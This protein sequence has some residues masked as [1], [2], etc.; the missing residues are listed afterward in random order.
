[1]KQLIFFVCLIGTLLG[2][3]KLI[4][5]QELYDLVDKADTIT[6]IDTSRYQKVLF[7]SHDKEDIKS[8]KEA[9]TLVK[10]EPDDYFALACISHYF[11]HFSTNKKELGYITIKGYS[12]IKYGSWPSEIPIKNR[13]KWLE[14]FDKRGMTML[15]EE[16]SETALNRWHDAMPKCLRGYW[17]DIKRPRYLVERELSEILSDKFKSCNPDKHKRVLALLKWF[18]SGE[19]SWSGFPEYE[20]DVEKML[21]KYST[22]DILDAVK[23]ASLSSAQKEGLAKLL[24][25]Y[26][27]RKQRKDKIPK[28]IKDMLWRFIKNTTSDKDKL[29]RAKRAFRSKQ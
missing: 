2:S 12:N 9:L 23:S 5:Y 11:I 20:E 4:N 21:L 7:I 19:G 26:S 8:F 3:E 18:G 25:G 28:K 22:K 13:D 17:G 1:M 6:V 10:L 16:E 15:R 14:W 24:A 29:E 27:F